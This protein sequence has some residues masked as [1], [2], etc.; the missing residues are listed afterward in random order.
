M[1]DKLT[2][3]SSTWSALACTLKN[4]KA[5]KA[6]DNSTATYGLLIKFTTL[7]MSR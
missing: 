6:E 4:A 3:H 5:P 7:K 2:S 1:A